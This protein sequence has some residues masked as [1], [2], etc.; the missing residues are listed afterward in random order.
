MKKGQWE[1]C[2]YSNVPV[3]RE[4]LFHCQLQDTLRKTAWL[5]ALP[6]TENLHGALAAP[7]GPQH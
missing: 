3:T 1:I 7:K 4:H 2:P 6:L 5:K